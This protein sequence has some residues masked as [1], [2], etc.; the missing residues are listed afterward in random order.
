VGGLC[1]NAPPGSR[2]D[3]QRLLR[4]HAGGLLDALAADIEL[5]QTLREQE[6]RSKGRGTEHRLDVVA[7]THA[8][9]RVDVGF[10]VMQLISEYRALRASVIR[11]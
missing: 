4:D 5:L 1:E 7:E 8:G 11:L 10:S 3:A 9:M 6:E 2:R